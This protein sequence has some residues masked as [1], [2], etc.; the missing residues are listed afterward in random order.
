MPCLKWNSPSSSDVMN[1]PSSSCAARRAP[2]LHLRALSQR[3]RRRSCDRAPR[4]SA[5]PAEPSAT[6]RRCDGR[7]LTP[8]CPGARSFAGADD[9]AQHLF[10]EQWI[11]RRVRRSRRSH[12]V[13]VA[14][15]PWRR[16][17]AS[18]IVRSSS[19]PRV[20]GR[21][22]VGAKPPSSFVRRRS[23]SSPR[24]GDSA[25]IRSRRCEDASSSQCASSTTNTSGSSTTRSITMTTMSA[26]RSRRY[27]G[28]IAS[29]SA[30]L[31]S[32]TPVTS[33]RSG[34]YADMSGATSTSSCVKLDPSGDSTPKSPR[35]VSRSARYGVAVV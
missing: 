12:A 9:G 34:A 5:G 6:L 32:S 3:D 26:R 2:D 11:R 7:Q 31:G 24:S 21:A 14:L 23:L 29:T 25:V 10:E 20:S 1:S 4:R 22:T 33:P 28:S 27:C 19:G 30:V 15:M 16:R 17:R 18:S 8:T 13:E 35:I